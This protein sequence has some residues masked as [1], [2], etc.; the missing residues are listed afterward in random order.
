MII[1]NNK[2]IR[3]IG[4]PE[5]SLTDGA[6]QWFLLESK[7]PIEIIT[8]KTFLSLSNKEDYQYFVGFTLDMNLRKVVCEE[9]DNLDLDCVSYIHDFCVVF[10]TCKMGK[11]IFIGSF[12]SIGYHSEIQNHCWIECY[13]MISHHVSLGKGSVVH[14]G[15]L[16]AGRVLIGEYCTFNF[17]S[18][19]INNVTLTDRVTLG[20]FSNATKNITKSG[21]YVGSIA[22]YV[23]E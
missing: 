2:P 8:P 10:D 14:A 6:L 1:E 22:R 16:I 9:I 19:I 13:S 20:A 4:Y 11:G 12:S 15:T 7:N 23:G 5:S 21:K 18:S 17:K 3:I